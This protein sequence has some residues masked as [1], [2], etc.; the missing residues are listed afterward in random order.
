MDDFLTSS[1]MDK[2][3]EQLLAGLSGL[4]LMAEFATAFWRL[5]A[6]MG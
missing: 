2:H 4:M 5:S 6:T 1:S 3:N